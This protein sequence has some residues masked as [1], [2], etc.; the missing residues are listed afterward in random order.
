[1]YLRILVVSALLAFSGCAST[2]NVHGSADNG[3]TETDIISVDQF[4]VM[5]KPIQVFFFD[6]T[7]FI[8]KQYPNH[9]QVDE[10]TKLGQWMDY[11]H[12]NIVYVFMASDGDGKYSSF[13]ILRGNPSNTHSEM[14]YKVDVLKQQS[15]NAI[16]RLREGYETQPAAVIED[17]SV[18]GSLFE[19]M[20]CFQTPGGS[21]FVGQGIKFYGKFFRVT[22]YD[23]IRKAIIP[24][25]EWD[26]AKK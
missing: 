20:A 7:I 24:I 23:E 26:M 5:D 16:E 13:Y 11:L 6:P 9:G 25:I 19:H 3:K 8:L 22:R 14:F 10:R 18:K 21:R 12:N 4:S 1:M 2:G 15:V 17:V